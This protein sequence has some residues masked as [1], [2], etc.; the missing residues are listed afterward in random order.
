M[1]TI[2]ITSARSGSTLLCSALSQHP[3]IKIPPFSNFEPFAKNTCLQHVKKTAR[4]FNTFKLLLNQLKV[5]RDFNSI[6]FLKKKKPKIIFLNRNLFDCFLSFKIAKKT[7]IWHIKKKEQKYP[8]CSIFLNPQQVKIF[9]DNHTKKAN[10]WKCI[11]SNCQSI[12]I[13]YTDL[14]RRWND[15]LCE[16]QDFIG[17]EQKKLIKHFRPTNPQGKKSAINYND[18]VSFF[19]DTK[20]SHFFTTITHL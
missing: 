3:S 5:D 15:T 9:F 16:V 11:F 12:E 14:V 6:M 18:I 13:Q 7:R 4:N 8:N 17:I 2:I 20:Y 10:L 19:H 1:P